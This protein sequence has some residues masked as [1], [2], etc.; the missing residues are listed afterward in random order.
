MKM[1][2]MNELL[3][4]LICVVFACASAVARAGTVSPSPT[5]LWAQEEFAS[6]AQKVFGRVPDAR[7]VLPGETDDFADDFRAL[8]GSGGGYAVRTRGETLYFIAEDPRGHVNAVHRWLEK[9]SDI[10]WPRPANDL[11]FYTPSSFDLKPVTCN[12]LDI[13]AY[14]VR[15]IE[16]GWRDPEAIRNRVRNGDTMLC[17]LKRIPKG[18]EGELRRYGLIGCGDIWGT[19]HDMETYWFP[20][21]EFF[22]GHPE[23][24]ME[25]DGRRWTGPGSNFCESNPDFVKAYCSSVEEKIATLPPSV[26]ILSINMEDQ[27][28]TCT[29]A[30]CLKPITLADGT[31]VAKDDPAFRSTR[32]FIFF[33]EV[34]RHVA[35]LRPDLVIRQFAYNHLTT[36]PKVKV[37]PNVILKW[38]PYPRDMR[39]PIVKGPANEVWKKRL[40]GW[41]ANTPN[42]YLREYYWCG[43]I[44]FPRP[45]ADT[46]AVDLRYCRDRGVREFYT[47]CTRVDNPSLCTCFGMSRPCR[48]FYDMNAMEVWVME[49]LLWDPSQDPAALRREF[50][51]RTFGPAAGAA[52]GDQ[53]RVATP[54]ETVRDGATHLVV[55]RPILAAE[56]PVAAAKAIRAEM[57]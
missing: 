4:Q 41:L 13:P 9:N 53:K 39:F 54:A 26:R 18:L 57:G 15:T 50:L 5:T 36:P 17:D 25:I 23:W 40:D 32:F 45:I 16:A 3:R 19:G 1:R 35:K 37:E 21:K 44:F 34:A 30:N 10:I 20:R 8:K 38:C 14:R 11:C 24:W 28:L 52:V 31:V 6:F 29:C 55:G 22:A 51:R 49:R 7:F 27:T 47:E 56:D 33:N 2:Q 46:A 42:V 48:E 43:C 12:Y